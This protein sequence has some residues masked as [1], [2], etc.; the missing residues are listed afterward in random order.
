MVDTKDMAKKGQRTRRKVGR[1]SITSRD[2]ILTV[3]LDLLKNGGD[4]ELSIRKIAARLGVSA[5]A[6]YSYFNDKHSLIM[7][8]SEGM[9][10]IMDLADEDGAPEQRL[11]SHLNHLRKQL[12]ERSELIALLSA[13][14][15]AGKMIEVVDA[16]AQPILAAGVEEGQAYRH[17]Q[18]LFWMTLSFT[19]FET[20]GQET[21]V[22]DQFM[23]LPEHL[24]KVIQHLD[25]HDHQRLW[26]ETVE[27][28]LA[29]IFH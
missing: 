4:S 13:A 24:E 16:L 21:V 23:Q 18:S 6:I 27:R 19:L 17:A 22:V 20:N 10:D 5:P 7:A 28:N 1:P 3:A 8:L 15:P 26:H 29:G 25:I 12:L 9:L 11:R 2:E 14:L